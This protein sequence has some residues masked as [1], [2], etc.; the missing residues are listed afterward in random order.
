[1]RSDLVLWLRAREENR[2]PD[3]R[4]TSA[5][6]CRLSYSGGT[7][8]DSSGARRA[9][10]PF[11]GLRRPGVRPSV[12]GADLVAQQP[13][14]HP[15]RLNDPA[16]FP[17]AQDDEP[18]PAGGGTPAPAG[19]GSRWGSAGGT[20][21][22]RRCGSWPRRGRGAGPASTRASRYTAASVARPRRSSAVRNRRTSRL[23]RV[24]RSLR[25]E[26]RRP[27]CS[28][29]SSSAA[30]SAACRSC[31]G[32]SASPI[33]D[34]SSATS[35]AARCPVPSSRR[36]TSRHAWCR[37]ASRSSVARVRARSRSPG[38]G[39]RGRHG[40]VAVDTLGHQPVGHDLGGQGEQ[41]DPH[42]PAGDG[43]QL[44]NDLG[45]EQHEHRR[46]R[47]LLDGLEQVAGGLV[48]HVLAAVGDDHLAGALDRR[49]R[50]AAHDP[51]GVALA[52]RVPLGLDQ[53]QVGVLPGQRQADVALAGGLVGG[54]GR[55]QRGGEGVGQRLL[56]RSRR[57]H[58]QVGVDRLAD[59]GRQP[60]DGA[61]LA[62]HVPPGFRGGAAGG[63]LGSGRG[64]HRAIIAE[65]TPPAERPPRRTASPAPPARGGGSSPRP[66][67]RPRRRRPAPCRR[68]SPS[69]AG[70]A[71]ASARYPRATRSWKSAPAASSRSGAPEARV[72]G[73][74]GR[75]VEQDDEVGPQVVGRPGGDPPQLHRP[76][77]PARAPGTPASNRRSG[78]TPRAGRPPA[79][80]A[81]PRRRAGPGRRP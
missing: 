10:S 61:R 74:L 22:R 8:H 15:E 36:G 40:T 39:R 23:W 48:L 77:G 19:A 2:T 45:R 17:A 80:A 30:T 4:I 59:R 60:A 41:L 27:Y 73:H 25:P 70:S 65:G 6:L 29:C 12:L 14:R 35:V 32:P 62:D 55:Q 7:G 81:R 37:S 28:I 11:A 53:P 76:A 47:R 57:P 67:P 64:A 26:P 56:A 75:H 68:W 13:Q 58:Q 21:R 66:T 51:L 38:R 42:A 24:S 31:S 18:G 44:G 78:R 20:P 1:M 5:L 34:C 49:Q 79:P 52:E 63:G 9:R 71:L 16:A 3:L 50:G 33:I 72:D 54:A 69:A 43:D 46:R